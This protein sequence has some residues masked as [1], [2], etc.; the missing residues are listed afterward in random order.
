MTAPM[1]ER[2]RIEA[3]ILALVYDE[4]KSQFDAD[5]AKRVIAAAVRKSA[6]AQG[7][8]L[9]Q[10]QGGETSLAAF[11]ELQKLWTAGGTLEVEPGRQDGSHYEFTVKRCMYAEM[12]Q[13]MGLGDLGF[14]LSCN[15]DG[16]LC[17]GYD[18]KLK[19]ARS[20]TIM[21]GAE[22]CDFKFTYGD[23]DDGSA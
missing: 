3:E 13:D 4:L 21:E 10:Q 14:T 16:T 6:I 23:Q 11:V 8:F 18:S 9:A 15:R 19:L 1:L 20:Q 2:R 7:Q 22:H 17:E 5:T 12:Y